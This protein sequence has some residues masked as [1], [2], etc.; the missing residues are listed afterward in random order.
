M[1]ARGSSRLW[2]EMIEKE[3]MYYIA[4]LL[5]INYHQLILKVDLHVQ[6]YSRQLY[7]HYKLSI[8]V[9]TFKYRSKLAQTSVL[10]SSSSWIHSSQLLCKS[11]CTNKTERVNRPFGPVPA[12]YTEKKLYIL[13]M[14]TNYGVILNHTYILCVLV[15]LTVYFLQSFPTIGSR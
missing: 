8:I 13:I 15:F 7:S 3:I 14:N 2:S 4:Q 11:S 10:F 9:N 12:Y 5:F 1:R 6:H